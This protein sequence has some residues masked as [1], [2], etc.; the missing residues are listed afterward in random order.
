MEQRGDAHELE[1]LDRLV[2]EIKA[3]NFEDG[4]TAFLG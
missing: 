3:I 2:A 4:A 1:R